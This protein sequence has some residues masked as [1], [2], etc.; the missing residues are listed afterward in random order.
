MAEKIFVKITNKDIYIKLECME[1]RLESIE[2][3]QIITNGKVKAHT[4][5]MYTG[6]SFMLTFLGWFVVHLM[7][8]H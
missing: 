1:A 6:G 4:I 8:A 5:M 2:K 7:Q 3:N